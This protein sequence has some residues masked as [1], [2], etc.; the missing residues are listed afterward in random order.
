MEIIQQF[1]NKFAQQTTKENKYLQEEKKQQIK[2]IFSLSWKAGEGGGAV[3]C[4]FSC[5]QPTNTLKLERKQKWKT[6]QVE[7]EKSKRKL[8]I[9][10]LENRNKCK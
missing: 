3:R 5:K 2:A 4:Q 10:F 7:K 8:K 1:I 9:D 6:M